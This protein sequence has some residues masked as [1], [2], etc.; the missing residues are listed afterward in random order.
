MQNPHTQQFQPAHPIVRE[1]LTSVGD[2]W[3]NC[4]Y[5]S[6]EQLLLTLVT[7][8]AVGPTTSYALHF[9]ASLPLQQNG[10]TKRRKSYLHAN[11]SRS[12]V[13]QMEERWSTAFQIAMVR[14]RRRNMVLLLRRNT[15][16]R[17]KTS[18]DNVLRAMQLTVFTRLKDTYLW[19][20]RR[21]IVCCSS[22]LGILDFFNGKCINAKAWKVDNWCDPSHHYYNENK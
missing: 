6:R 17:G 15:L 21:T 19:K 4:I 14:T 8:W 12:S 7:Y 1:P 2:I 10:S 20:L 11:P 18:F 5:C 9:I 22:L 16:C 13:I 3:H